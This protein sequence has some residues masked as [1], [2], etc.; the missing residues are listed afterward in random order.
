MPPLVDKAERLLRPMF[1]EASKLIHSACKYPLKD[2]L[3]QGSRKVLR[4]LKEKDLVCL[5]SDKG[6]E[7][8]VTSPEQYSD[9]AIYRRVP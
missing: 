9:A 3:P 2:N 5:P 8:Y 6:G 4:T 7:F 1:A